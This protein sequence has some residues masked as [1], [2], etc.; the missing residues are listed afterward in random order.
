MMDRDSSKKP[1]EHA[2]KMLRLTMEAPEELRDESYVQIIKQITN[3]K[4][5]AKAL[6]GWNLFALMAS[7]YVPSEK[8][9]YSLLNYLFDIIKNSNLSESYEIES[10]DSKTLIKYHANYVII[11]LYKTYENKRYNLPND[12]EI[13]H[14]EVKV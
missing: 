11:R 7:T 2:K 5:H 1:I 4:D 12:D 10:I 13:V 9:Y 3:H 8:L 14:V 6:R